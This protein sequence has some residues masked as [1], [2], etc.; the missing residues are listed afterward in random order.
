[1]LTGIISFKEVNALTEEQFERFDELHYKVEN[2]LLNLIR[3]L[4]EKQKTGGWEDSF[5]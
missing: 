1:L 4:Q 2:E 5:V 3:S